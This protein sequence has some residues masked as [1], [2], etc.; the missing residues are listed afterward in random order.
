MP[1]GY[2]ISG[3]I[4]YKKGG[5][6]NIRT[7]VLPAPVVSDSRT[8]PLETIDKS[9]CEITITLTMAHP[10]LRIFRESVET[11][12]VCGNITHFLNESGIY[13]IFDLVKHTEKEI[14]QIKGI[15]PRKLTEIKNALNM[16]DGYVYLG[17][18]IPNHIKK[19]FL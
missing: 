15:G 11:L 3:G 5:N 19:Y 4:T 10:M 6:E 17:M 1:D 2:I 7:Y 18:D 9:C 14:K 12:Y 8:I 16:Y 13:S